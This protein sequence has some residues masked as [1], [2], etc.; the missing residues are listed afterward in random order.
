MCCVF[1]YLKVEDSHTPFIAEGQNTTI[2]TNYEIALSHLCWWT[3]WPCIMRPLS[4]PKKNTSNP[5]T[6]KNAKMMH[7]ASILSWAAS[8][9]CR[10]WMECVAKSGKPRFCGRGSSIRSSRVQ[11]ATDQNRLVYDTAL[12]IFLT[13]TKQ[14]GRNIL[15]ARM[16]MMKWSFH[17]GQDTSE[18]EVT[19]KHKKKQ[20]PALGKIS[21]CNLRITPSTL[22]LYKGFDDWR[23]DLCFFSPL[24]HPFLTRPGL[25]P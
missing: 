12:L 6:S 17:R 8:K 2:H 21:A 4:P 19:S 13:K 24:S 25:P 10:F 15:K 3:K 18:T 7:Q 20:L 14:H 16:K 22:V 5:K 1:S 11:A 23:V 9:V